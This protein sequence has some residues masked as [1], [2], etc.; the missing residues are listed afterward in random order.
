VPNTLKSKKKLNRF[1]K[2]RDFYL[3]K[4]WHKRFADIISIAIRHYKRCN[5]IG[6]RYFRKPICRVVIRQYNGAWSI[7]R[8]PKNVVTTLFAKLFQPYIYYSHLLLLSNNQYEKEIYDLLR[9]ENMF[10]FLPVIN[11]FYFGLHRCTGAAV[12][13]SIHTFYKSRPGSAEG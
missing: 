8:Q 4:R 10:L 5:W 1:S 11:F 6:Q 12:C 3:C 13:A 7:H 2:K 9:V